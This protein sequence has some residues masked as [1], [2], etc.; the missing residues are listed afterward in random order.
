MIMKFHV[1]KSGGRVEYSRVAML[2]SLKKDAE[3]LL[4]SF[5]PKTPRDGIE[6]NSIMQH[7]SDWND[8]KYEP[9]TSEQCGATS[10]EGPMPREAI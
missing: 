7:H 6:I 9:S 2:G 4:V 8:S 1:S 10:G 3:F 5:R